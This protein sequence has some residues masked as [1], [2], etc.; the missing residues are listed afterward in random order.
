MTVLRAHPCGRVAHLSLSLTGMVA[1]LG[2]GKGR[3]GEHR[4]VMGAYLADYRSN[5]HAGPSQAR[6][7]HQSAELHEFAVSWQTY[8][9]CELC[10]SISSFA[11]AH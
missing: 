7:A 2:T 5:V 11:R 6:L 9:S 8:I 4:D 10:P 1:R 3:V